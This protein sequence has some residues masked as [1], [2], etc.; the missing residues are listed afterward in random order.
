MTV[1]LCEN[2]VEGIL[3]GVYAAWT[4]RKGHSNVK[5]RLMGDEDTMELFCQYIDVPVD[6][7]NAD[8]VAEAIRKKISEDAY[9]AVYKAA[10]SKEADRADKIYRFLIYGFHIGAGVV[11]ML[12][13]Q[14]V[15]DIF[16]MCRHIDNETHLLTGFVRFVEME[17]DLLVSR[18]GPKNDVLVLLAPHFAD[19]LSGENWVLYDENRKKAALHPALRPWFLAD[20]IS[21]EWEER[22]KKASLEDEYEE[23]YKC[24]RR[25]IS[26]KER[27]NPV[28]QR[29]HMPLRY[30]SYMPEFSNGLKDN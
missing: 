14:E 4:G 21:E 3:S 5:L 27:T 20:F 15:Y 26:I 16:Q 29:N 18:I 24:F 2:S 19:R 10:L 17:G 13:V 9:I 11:N 7:R 25:S 22:L 12:Q 28:C 23:L 8:K 30:R 6:A 1:Y